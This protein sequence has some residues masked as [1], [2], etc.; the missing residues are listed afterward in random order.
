MKEKLNLGEGEIEGEIEKE[1]FK[2]K[3]NHEGKNESNSKLETCK[4][5]H[6]CQTRSYAFDEKS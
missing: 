2:K 3:L 6:K 4:D 1:K 5:P